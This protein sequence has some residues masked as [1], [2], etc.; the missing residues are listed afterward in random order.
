MPDDPEH[1][2]T[3]GT[4]AGGHPVDDWPPPA[5]PRAG[6][7]DGGD[8][9]DDDEDLE[10]DRG[11][12]VAWRSPMT[13]LPR[14]DGTFF[15]AMS[16]PLRITLR[17]AVEEL[18][19]RLLGGNE[20]T[21]RLFPPAYPDHPDL[22]AEYRELMFGELLESRLAALDLVESTI[23]EEV[24]TEEQ[25][26]AWA[27]V[28]NGVRLCIGTELEVEETGLDLAEDDPRLPAYVL[29]ERL[30]LMLSY[31]VDVLPV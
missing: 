30:G 7:P 28:I 8:G 29:Y 14:S 4:D 19:R 16:E 26:V 31:I 12:V 22:D 21:S 9:P 3:E 20:S 25:L 6:R 11:V 10:D 23:D 2:P 15:V 24:V 5:H 17:L 13:V 27:Q 18:R 1:L